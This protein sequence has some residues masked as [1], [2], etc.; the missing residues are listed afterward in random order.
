M[1]SC[2]ENQSCMPLN[3]PVS[4]LSCFSAVCGAQFS[5]GPLLLLWLPCGVRCF[6]CSLVICRIT[7]LL[8]RLLTFALYRNNCLAKQRCF[9]TISRETAEEAYATGLGRKILLGK[10]RLFVYLQIGAWYRCGLGLTNN[11]RGQNQLIM[12]VV[13]HPRQIQKCFDLR[14][15]AAGTNRVTVNMRANLRC[16]CSRFWP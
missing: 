7:W 6:T 9:Q 5:K 15:S 2:G 8:C 16:K 14:H 1:S 13:T 4:V 12:H 10:L 3:W 11:Y